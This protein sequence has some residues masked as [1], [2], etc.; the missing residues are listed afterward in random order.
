MKLKALLLSLLSAVGFAQAKAEP[1]N[2]N[3]LADAIATVE[4]TPGRGK[5]GERSP[6][7]FTHAVWA[8]HSGMSF[9]YADVES[10][11]ARAEQRRVAIAHA[12]Y[13]ATSID[14][15]TPYRIALA[16]NAGIAAVLHN[17]FSDASVGYA[18]RV[19]NVYEEACK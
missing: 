2:W 15:P 19:R 5:H 6:W 12:Q 9:S 7:Q 1:I 3:K 14:N 11:Q 4:N 13:I 18:K 16:W 17:T 8:L 10:V